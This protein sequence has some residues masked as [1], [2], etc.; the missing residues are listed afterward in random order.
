MKSH[1]A[2]VF[3]LSAP[4]MAAFCLVLATAG[5]TCPGGEPSQGE[6]GAGA[7]PAG[8]GGSAT[9]DGGGGSATTDGGSGT[10]D[11]GSGTTDGGG[12]QQPCSQDI[13]TDVNHCGACD[14]PCAPPG[15]G[16]GVEFPSCAAGVCDSVCVPG[17]LNL[18]LP[19]AAMGM[20]DGCESSVHRVFVTQDPTPA[21]L[22]GAFGADA[23]CQTR[24]NDAGLTGLWGAWISDTV[25]SPSDRFFLDLGP[26]VRMDGTQI[27][28]NW[29]DLIDGQ[30]DAPIELS[31]AM[32]GIQAFVWTGTNPDGTA[33]L[34]ADFCSDWTVQ[35]GNAAI[36][37]S[38]ATD[39]SWSVSQSK[40][41]CTNL[42]HLYCFEQIAQ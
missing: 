40:P 34:A 20:D 28:V 30:L 1:R 25:S 15:N 41:T 38:L 2:F 39:G 35:A 24:A 26:Y 8:G 31:E 11:G 12:G 22:G 32:Q 5:F 14:R 16:S 36:G 21:T 9:T 18:F 7:L 37:F 33:E 29:P 17:R 13:M 42:F 4:L 6:G 19:E 27:A 3:G 10:T 23:L